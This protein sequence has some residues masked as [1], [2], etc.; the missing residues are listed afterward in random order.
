MPSSEEPVP[1]GSGV[2]LAQSATSTWRQSP[3]DRRWFRRMAGVLVAFAAILVARFEV[4]DSPPYWDSILAVWNEADYLAKSDFDYNGLL[5]EQRY[6]LH[7]DG[8]RRAYGMTIIPGVIAL[9]MRNT[10]SPRAAIV[11]YRL[12]IFLS[13]ACSAVLFFELVRPLTTRTGAILATLATWTT[14]VFAVQIDLLGMEPPLIALAL[15]NVFLIAKGR[16]GWAAAAALG[17]FA[18][19]QSGFI[20]VAANI[21]YFLG[22]VV[23]NL[24]QGRRVRSHSQYV[25]LHVAVAALEILV[26]SSGDTHT[27]NMRGGANWF[28]ALTWCPDVVLLVLACLMLGIVRTIAWRRRERDSRLPVLN[29]S[30]LGSEWVVAGWTAVLALLATGFVPFLPRYVA[31]AVPFIYLVLAALLFWSPRSAMP[32]LLTFAL[33]TMFNVGNWNGRFFPDVNALPSWATSVQLSGIARESGHLERSHEYLR[34]HRCTQQVVR[35]IKALE[36]GQPVL[37]GFPFTYILSMPSLGYVDQP[38]PTYALQG[39]YDYT[40]TSRDVA[41]LCDD[42]PSRPVFILAENSF[43]RNYSRFDSPAPDSGTILFADSKPGQLVVFRSAEPDPAWDPARIAAWYR[44]RSFPGDALDWYFA[45]LWSTCQFDRFCESVARYESRQRGWP[46][47][48]AIAAALFRRGRARES[49]DAYFAAMA[50]DWDRFCRGNP[51][52]HVVSRTA[53]LYPKQA[54]EAARQLAQLLQGVEERFNGPGGAWEAADYCVRQYAGALADPYLRVFLEEENPQIRAVLAPF[55]QGW[56][57]LETLSL[58]EARRQFALALEA[59]PEFPP[60]LIGLGIVAY[61]ENRYDDAE[62]ALAEAL[63]LAPRSGEASYHLGLVRRARQKSVEHFKG[64]KVTLDLPACDRYA[65][66]PRRIATGLA[67]PSM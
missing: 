55:R 57:A 20:V 36:P 35:V 53:D 32:G 46:T 43:Y 29:S 27:Q 45:R 63:R 24:L 14:P 21:V 23:G 33:L 38:I 39:F 26:I 66:G 49:T 52:P 22:M 1:P 58:G 34:D 64:A 44:D 7:P 8:G 47:Q 9:F 6:C 2:R 15:L 40:T 5:H 18:V 4:I 25:L 17:A 12:L 60:A 11:G 56:S 37:C 31:L 54:P 51:L 13:S 62:Q 19:K 48:V 50:R 59:R 61:L 65:R 10:P 30:L 3:A 28:A 42:H 67:T 41:Q 16:T